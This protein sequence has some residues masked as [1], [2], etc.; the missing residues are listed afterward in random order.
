MIAVDTDVL[1]RVLVNDPGAE[2]QCRLAR[3]LINSHGDMW[4]F[5]DC[6]GRKTLRPIFAFQAVFLLK[7][8]FFQDL[9]GG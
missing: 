9:N 8:I 5:K 7:A 3:N 4:G 2:E 1:V 6:F